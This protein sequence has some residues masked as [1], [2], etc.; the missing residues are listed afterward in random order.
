VKA[1]GTI[2][3]RLTATIEPVV[4][5]VS[6]AVRASARGRSTTYRLRGVTDRPLA[7]GASATVRF[8]LSRTALAG[9]RRALRRHGSARAAISVSARDR[10]GNLT[11][12]KRTVTLRR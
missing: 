2:T 4:A 11:T 12:A 8:R 9:V 6:V 10:A 5:S 3:V 7:P 1:S